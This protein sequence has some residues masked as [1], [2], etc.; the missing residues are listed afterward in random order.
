M[1]TPHTDPFIEMLRQAEPSN[2]ELSRWLREEQLLLKPAHAL[3]F[4]N[5]TLPT[6]VLVEFQETWEKAMR[7][8]AMSWSNVP[9][10]K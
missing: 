8:F 2:S 10:L 3:I 1:S 9:I 7:R 5:Q 6:E 4:F